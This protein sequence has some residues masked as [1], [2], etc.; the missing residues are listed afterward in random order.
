MERRH[1]GRMA[2][3]LAA[4]WPVARAL[5]FEEQAQK[6]LG[7]AVA[8][9]WAQ[10]E[11]SVG[12]RLGVA[13]LDAASGEL[14]GHRLDERFPM[15]STFKAL[16]VALMLARVDA[17]QER[18]DRR[19]VVPRGA[20]LKWAPVA[21][22]HVGGAGMT[23]GELCEAAITVSDNTAANLLL[24][25][26]GG[27]AGVTTFARRL[28]DDVTR[29]DR[30]EPTLNEARPGDPRDTSTPRAM[31]QTLRRVLLGDALSEAGRAQ[32][33][34][35]MSATTTGAQRLRAGVPFDWR[36]ADKTG[37]GDLGSTND[38]GV[39][40]PPRRAPL[41]VVAYLT[42]CSAPPDA[43]AAALADVAR[44]VTGGAVALRAS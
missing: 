33:V 31:A 13:V 39:L 22:Q 9:R 36:V 17:G 25:S 35:W 12:G 34:R 29:L 14:T 5:G 40:W 27:P 44:S 43:R 7:P 6:N 1:F 30:T 26:S 23:V 21:R 28:G 41:V 10:I 19:I 24:E 38:I 4:G 32:L 2:V 37:T 3:A 11:A 15:C 18:L 8:R 20:L 16:A 42:Q